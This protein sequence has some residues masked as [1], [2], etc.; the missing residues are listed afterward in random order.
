MSAQEKENIFVELRKYHLD[1]FPKSLSSETMN[2]LR[3]EFGEF[4]DKLV[5]MLLSLVNGRAEYVDLTPD[6]DKIKAKAE[7]SAST[8]AIENSDRELL[9]SKI[10][11]LSNILHMASVGTFPL[12]RK[13]PV[14]ISQSKKPVTVKH[15]N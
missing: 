10:K 15:K 11:Q 2:E 14:R 9:L 7:I 8:E 12:K 6:L 4:E 5:T 13:R 1:E 3:T